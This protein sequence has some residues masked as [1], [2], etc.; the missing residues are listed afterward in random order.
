MTEVPGKMEKAKPLPIRAGCVALD[1][2]AAYLAD[3][4]IIDAEMRRADILPIAAS[5]TGST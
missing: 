1:F 5:R 2:A 4:S 3:P